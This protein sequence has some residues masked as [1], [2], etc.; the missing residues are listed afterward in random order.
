MGKKWY[1]KEEKR[2]VILALVISNLLA[3]ILLAV[4][5]STSRVSCHAIGRNDYGK[6][7]KTEKF[8][9]SVGEKVTK[10]PVTIE[11]EERAYSSKEIQAVFSTCMERLDTLILGTNKSPDNIRN[12]LNLPTKM[13]GLPIQISWEMDNY[14]VI[15]LDGELQQDKLNEKGTL[16]KLKGTLSYKKEKA[17]YITSVNIYPPLC[18]KKEQVV[19]QVEKKTKK[20]DIDTQEKSKLFLPQQVDGKKVIW[21]KPMNTRAFAISFMGL[22]AAALLIALRKQNQRKEE[23]VRRRQMLID[24]PE[25]I[26]QFTLLVGAGMT[27]KNTWKKIISEYQ[28]QTTWKQKR[29]AYEEMIYTYREMQSGVP[30]GECYERFGYRCRD[31][32]YI[33]FGA[34]LSQNLRKGSSGLVSLLAVEAA[35]AYANRKSLAKRLGEEAGTK[36]LIPMFGMLVVVL[37]IIIVPAF[38]SIQM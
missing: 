26:N 2:K 23:E 1:N 5:G 6:G 29:Y 10:E 25:I 27:V 17:Q 38:L 22:L 11:V 35:Q 30:E 19:A 4:D 8:L 32:T 9:V 33:K 21:T 28:E 18:N 36:L 7:K 3:L 14:K 20:K 34:L 37:V 31:Q 24:Y 15:N 16:V 12:N 13:P